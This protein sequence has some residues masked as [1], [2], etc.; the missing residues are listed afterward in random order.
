MDVTEIGRRILNWTHLV[1]DS[2]KCQT[3]VKT[4]MNITT[5][6]QAGNFPIG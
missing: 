5:P 4:T 3:L 6:Q 1:Q 2:N